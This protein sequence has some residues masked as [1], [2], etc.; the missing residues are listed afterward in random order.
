MREL[1][2]V[3]KRAIMKYVEQVPQGMAF[4]I[5]MLWNLLKNEKRTLII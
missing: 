4:I 2:F 3:L 1:L 5:R